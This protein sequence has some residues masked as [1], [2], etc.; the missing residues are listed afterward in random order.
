MQV[1][2][3]ALVLSSITVAAPGRVHFTWLMQIPSLDKYSAP[4]WLGASAARRF[5]VMAKPAGSACNLNCAYCFYLSKRQL[6]GGPGSGHMSDEILERFVSDYIRSV[7]ASEVVFSWQ[8]GEPTLLGLGFFEKVVALQARHARPGQRIENDLQTNGTLL[9]DDWAKFLK[10]HRFLVGLSIDGPRDIHDYYRVTKHTEPTFDSVYAAA[11]V[12]QRRGVAFNT[13]TCVHRYN[14]ARPLDVYRFLRRELGSTYLQFIP[15]V[16]PRDFETVAPQHGD[17]ASMTTVGSPEAHP[18]HENSVVTPWSVDPDEYGYFLCKVW[19]EW[20][21]RDVGKVLVNFCETLV[22]Q[23]MGQPS[24][25]CVHSE[26]CGKGVALEHNGDVYSC[27]HYVYP[28]YRLGNIRD[29]SLGDL[30]FSP[31]QVKFGYAKSESLPAYCRQCAFLSDCWGECPKN[32][33]LRTPDGEPGLNY[34][35]AGLK[36]F[37]AHAGPS[38]SRMAAKLRDSPAPVPT[39]SRF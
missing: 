5:H 21:A 35:C 7:T 39:A 10:Q 20:L 24:Q 32:R 2:L 30:L 27:D 12:L 31:R 34:L 8:G 15:I 36:R 17:P 14:A 16:E 18:G 28:E 11:K 4:Q 22:V 6:P 38:A 9:D 25:I 19:D 23:H 33:F 3:H 1:D 29:R 37:F 26:H 13:L